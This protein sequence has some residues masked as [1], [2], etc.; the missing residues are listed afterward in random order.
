MNNQKLYSIGEVA[1]LNNISIQTL[2]YYDKID[3]FKPASIDPSSNY[4]YYHE[5]QF[6]YLDIIK[7]LK[8]I[9]TPLSQI[10]EVMTKDAAQL[11]PFLE[12]QDLII[13]QKISQL[14]QAQKMLHNRKLQL[15]EQNILANRPRGQVYTRFV[16]AQDQLHLSTTDLTPYGNPD[17]YMRDLAH[18]L[19]TKENRVV[20]NFY[21]CVYD[22]K[23]YK[24][25][26]QIVYSS[27]YTS[28]IGNEQLSNKPKPDIT[29]K[30]MSEGMYVCIC[31]KWS[32]PHYF[33]HYKTLY[34]HIIEHNIITKNPV[35]EVSLPN[36]YFS[37]EEDDF[38]TELRI[39]MNESA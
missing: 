13:D 18:L 29:K 35:Y 30:H 27:I 37:Y 28:L 9:D 23:D 6:F 21:G 16:E 12:E 14:K 20:D 36:R 31:F 1:K 33:Q 26:E 8:Y 19:E 10:K 4:R 32:E 34:D 15:K 25:T 11:L 5:K 22:L 7:Y 3:L 39:K 24:D 17:V 2:R 38:I